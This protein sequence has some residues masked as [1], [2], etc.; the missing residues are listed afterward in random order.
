VK[1][2]AGHE[3]GSIVAAAACD[4]NPEPKRCDEN[5]GGCGRSAQEGA[6][7]R[8]GSALCGACE[9]AGAEAEADDAA[10]L[11]AA[12]ALVAKHRAARRVNWKGIAEQPNVVKVQQLADAFHEVGKINHYMVGV[13]CGF[14]R[15]ELEAAEQVLIDRQNAG[16][17][18]G[19]AFQAL[20]RALEEIEHAR[21]VKFVQTEKAKAGGA[22]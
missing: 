14:D 18:K 22:K 3:H 4:K 15:E 6:V 19:K 20:E 11:E 8:D 21:F 12:E 5:A 1:C 16:P 17:Q 13:T 7:L 9:E 2:R 10:K